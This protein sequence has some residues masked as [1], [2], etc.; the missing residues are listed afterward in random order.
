MGASFASEN[1]GMLLRHLDQYGI[2]LSNLRDAP[3]KGDAAFAMFKSHGARWCAWQEVWLNGLLALLRGQMYEA[4]TLKGAHERGVVVVATAE[5]KAKLQDAAGRFKDNKECAKN[6][7]DP[8]CVRLK[9]TCPPPP[10]FLGGGGG[11][12][13][14]AWIRV[15]A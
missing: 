5:F 6:S 15:C 1:I 11:G 7:F 4:Q 13:G 10:F 3:Q 8:E 9:Q 14:C 2:D 12:G